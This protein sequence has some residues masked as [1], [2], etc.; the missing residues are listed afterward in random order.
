[1]YNPP[2]V[3]QNTVTNTSQCVNDS[4]ES[5]A[6]DDWYWVDDG[7]EDGRD[8]P[9]VSR[10]RLRI[11][12]RREWRILCKGG[13]LVGRLIFRWRMIGILVVAVVAVVVDGMRIMRYHRSSCT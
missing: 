8:R 7:V 10:Q 4:I 1:V 3:F 6:H 9:W 13:G 11:G 12:R 2:A 5:R